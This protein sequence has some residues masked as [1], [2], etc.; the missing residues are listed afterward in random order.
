[1][2]LRQSLMKFVEFGGLAVIIVKI[3]LSQRPQGDVGDGI[4][5]LNHALLL[6]GDGIAARPLSVPDVSPSPSA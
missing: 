6:R 3:S 1:M 2:G 4:A 5:V